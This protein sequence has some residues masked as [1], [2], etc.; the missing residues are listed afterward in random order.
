MKTKTQKQVAYLLSKV[1]PVSEEQ[2]KKRAQRNAAR[3]AMEKKGLVHK[4]DGK[5]VDHRTPLVKGGG[6]GNGNLRVVPA[7]QNRSFART[8]SAG[9]K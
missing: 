8:K 3:A 9:M 6:N 1:S 4:G 2:K 5:D 7:S